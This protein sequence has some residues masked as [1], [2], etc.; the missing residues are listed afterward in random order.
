MGLKET[1]D[2][3]NKTYGPGTLQMMSDRP[4]MDVSVIPS[5][6]IA[7]DIALGIGGYPRGRIIELF[8]TESAGK[9]TLALHAVAE[10]QKLGENVVYVDSEHSLDPEYA[11][12]I[13]VDVD[14]LYISQPD[15]GEMGLAVALKAAES[16]EVSLVI[17]D[18]VAAL[19][20]RAEI[21]GDLGDSHMGLQARLMS[22]A[23][24][25]M[26]G[27]AYMN[28]TILLFINQIREKIGV[29]FGSNETT[30]GGRALK[31]YAS[32]RLDIRRIGQIKDGVEIVGN[33]TRV[34]IVKN[35]CARP[36]TVAE[37][38]IIYGNGMSQDGSIIDIGVEMKLLKKSG[39]WYYDNNGESLGQGREKAKATLEADPKLAASI[40][41]LIIKKIES[42][43]NSD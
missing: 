29:M 11:A 25:K 3:L 9:T 42:D 23:M 43:N 5:G 6:N 41:D 39:A 28:G 40:Y 22:Q 35:K 21:A 18:S 14:K 10:A 26:N 17:I 12:A 37:F 24:R 33:Q 19:T 4:Q 38:D 2:E 32:Q 31:F 1:V 27:A 16:G 36:F 8:G 7:L 15:Y 34:K 30:P 20:P 13:G